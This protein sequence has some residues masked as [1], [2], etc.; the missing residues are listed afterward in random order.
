MSSDCLTEIISGGAFVTLTVLLVPA[1]VAPDKTVAAG[2][3]GHVYNLRERDE[4]VKKET[5]IQARLFGLYRT[6]L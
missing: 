4:E 5:G 1:G 2:A 3:P 6:E